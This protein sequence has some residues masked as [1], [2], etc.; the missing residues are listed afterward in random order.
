MAHLRVSSLNPSGQLILVSSLNILRPILLSSFPLRSH[1]LLPLPFVDGDERS[2]RR[3]ARG[4]RETAESTFP[5]IGFTRTPD[6][7]AVA[8]L[9]SNGGGEIYL[10]DRLGRVTSTGSW[11]GVGSIALFDGGMHS[12]TSI[13]CSPL[14][15]LD[16][17]SSIVIYH[18]SVL[19]VHTFSK[20]SS[21]VLES[22]STSHT[23]PSQPSLIIL[24]SHSL[25][26]PILSITPTSITTFHLQRGESSTL[27]LHS[28][29][30]L[31]LPSN[32]DFILP[33][34][35]ITRAHGLPEA[36]SISPS[37]PSLSPTIPLAPALNQSEMELEHDVLVSVLDGHLAF[38][39]PD[40][41]TRSGWR[42]TGSVNTN[43]KNIR[44][45]RCSSVKKTAIGNLSA[46][47]CC[48]NRGS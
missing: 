23:P 45:A 42:C 26:T 3:I 22:L 19:T 36:S 33:V 30:C 18:D 11:E 20:G 12:S 31:P 43:R 17:G 48:E 5:I 1:E 28:I 2:I 41:D 14:N 27:T 21:T 34:D 24:P 8:S 6:G 9:R 46:F 25:I 32:P 13:R 39:M 16:A 7:S 35:S 4:A 38:W 15:L 37:S 40:K 29:S 10:R 44:M 47:V